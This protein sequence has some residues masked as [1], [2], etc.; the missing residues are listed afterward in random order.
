M[1]LLIH[2]QIQR[3]SWSQLSS[4]GYNTIGKHV[5]LWRNV[6]TRAV[7]KEDEL[8]SHIHKHGN[9][10]WTGFGVRVYIKNKSKMAL[11]SRDHVSDI[12]SA[13]VFPYVF[14]I[15]HF[16][17]KINW[18]RSQKHER[19]VSVLVLLHH[20][21]NID[22][23]EPCGWFFNPLFWRARCKRVIY[24]VAVFT[25]LFRDEKFAQPARFIFANARHLLSKKRPNFVRVI[26]RYFF[27]SVSSIPDSL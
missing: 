20:I 15:G 3:N 23:C 9:P 2:D 10:V 26:W 21:F 19:W 4:V 18:W 22:A 7:K 6:V 17:V 8:L 14:A 5:H 13:Y 1:I 25:V 24:Q 16:L 27:V 12:E 11:S